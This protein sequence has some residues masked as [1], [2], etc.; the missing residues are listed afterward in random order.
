MELI[1]T[2]AAAALIIFLL[3]AVIITATEILVQQRI[4]QILDFLNRD[5]D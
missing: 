1:T 2:V 3:A 4:N 5:D